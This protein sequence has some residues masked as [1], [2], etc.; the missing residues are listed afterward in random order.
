MKHDID[1]VINVPA[2][3]Y[4]LGD[5]CYVVREDE[6]QGWLQ[7]ADSR[8][9]W[10][11]LWAPTPSGTWVLGL[12]TQWGDGAYRD[13]DG[14]D[15]PVDSGLIG[16]VPFDYSPD[17]SRNAWSRAV[18]FGDHVRCFIDTKGTAFREGPHVLTFG[19]VRIDAG[20]ESRPSAGTLW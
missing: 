6:W 15:Y 20:D 2:G 8:E 13:E 5:P 12:T 10:Y 1:S 4:W 14:F 3:K 19:H 11:V 17:Y 18:V 9:E 16:L 7:A